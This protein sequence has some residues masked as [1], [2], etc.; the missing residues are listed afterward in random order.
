MY[1]L[2][3]VLH[4]PKMRRDARMAAKRK[5]RRGVGTTDEQRL[6]A[7][8]DSRIPGVIATSLLGSYK[9]ELETN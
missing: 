2:T 1:V 6:S 5:L 7:V 9:T 8:S 4:P 3:E